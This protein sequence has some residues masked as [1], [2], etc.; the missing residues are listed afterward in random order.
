MPHQFRIVAPDPDDRCV[1]TATGKI[2]HP[3]ADWSLLPP[4]EVFS[5]NKNS[6]SP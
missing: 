6:A 5:V 2:L 4:A 1:R 3:P